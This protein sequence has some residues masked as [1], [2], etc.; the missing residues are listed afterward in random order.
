MFC[1]NCGNEINDREEFCSKCG[2]KNEI[3]NESKQ[4]KILEQDNAGAEEKKSLSEIFN[5][6]DD[7]KKWSEKTT[8]EKIE[9]VY[10]AIFLMILVILAIK[11]HS[12]I[13]FLWRI[14]DS[15]VAFI[16]HFINFLCTLSVWNIPI[17]IIKVIYFAIK[18]KAR[19]ALYQL[20]MIPVCII[21]SVIASSILGSVGEEIVFFIAMIAVGFLLKIFEER[22]VNKNVL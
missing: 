17:C 7:D 4:E 9:T 8:D 14:A 19:K 12:E 22:V 6:D 5:E 21:Y 3:P 20:V 1:K 11:Y 2:T 18:S 16:I 15:K 13:A 10:N